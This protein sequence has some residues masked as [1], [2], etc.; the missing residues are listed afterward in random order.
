MCS[1]LFFETYIHHAF[2][3]IPDSQSRKL[4][5]MLSMQE[6]SL[7]NVQPTDMSL[8][9]KRLQ[10]PMRLVFR[11]DNQRTIAA[12]VWIQCEESLLLIWDALYGLLMHRK[13][14]WFIR[15]CTRWK[16]I[17]YST[18]HIVNNLQLIITVNN[19]KPLHLWSLCNFF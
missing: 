1:S 6:F 4:R 14:F 3:T 5:T 8:E 9:F 18:A 12:S 11:N 2:A 10:F 16:N 7:E 13:F 19:L 15:L 17:V